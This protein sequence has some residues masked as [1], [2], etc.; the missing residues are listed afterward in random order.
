LNPVC[1]GPAVKAPIYLQNQEKEDKRINVF[2]AIFLENG[3]SRRQMKAARPVK[4]DV[5]RFG[6]SC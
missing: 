4:R 6:F 1:G 2:S 5:P 3:Q